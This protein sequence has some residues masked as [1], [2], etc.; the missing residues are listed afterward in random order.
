MQEWEASVPATETLTTPAP[1]QSRA[2]R[3]VHL[4]THF[5]FTSRQ[6]ATI[7][8][9]PCTEEKA[10]GWEELG[11]QLE[12]MGMVGTGYQRQRKEREQHGY[13]RPLTEKCLSN[14]LDCV[15]Q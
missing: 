5:P 7:K 1:C 10:A 8:L 14:R 15:F 4:E 11:M 13:C 12:R 3:R 6:R 9:A 2:Q